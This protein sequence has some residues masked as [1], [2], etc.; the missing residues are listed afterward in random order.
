MKLRDVLKKP[1]I[2]EKSMLQTSLGKVTFLVDRRA[3]KREIAQ[4]V[5][6]FFK[7]KPIS[8]RT[9]NLAGKTKRSLKTRQSVFIPG[10]KKAIITLK[11]GDKIDIFEVGE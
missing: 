8:V 6:K 5:E 9:I 3:T 11:K 4:A 1:L 2:T 10:Q 7:V